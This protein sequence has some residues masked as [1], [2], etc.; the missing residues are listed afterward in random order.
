MSHPHPVLGFLSGYMPSAAIS[1]PT[2]PP[3][4]AQPPPSTPSPYSCSPVLPRGL[5]MAPRFPLAT[6]PTLLLGLNGRTKDPLPP[7]QQTQLPA[8]LEGGCTSTFKI[9]YL[10]HVPDHMYA[11]MCFLGGGMCV[12]SVCWCV[13]VRVC[14]C[15]RVGT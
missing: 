15:H 6:T 11:F 14:M 3:P 7:T 1:H 2:V 4:H 10:L 12:H 13:C 9:F 5:P 8:S